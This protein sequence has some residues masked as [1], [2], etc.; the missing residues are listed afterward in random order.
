MKSRIQVF[1]EE[2][3]GQNIKWKNSPADTATLKGE[4]NSFEGV[5]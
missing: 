3:N 4:G 5:F 2:G 1:L